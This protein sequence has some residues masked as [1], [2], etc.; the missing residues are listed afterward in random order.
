M[1]RVFAALL[2][3]CAAGTAAA[4]T[5]TISV[6]SSLAD[7]VREIGAAWSAGKPGVALRFNAAASGVLLQQVANGAPVDVLISADVETVER[8]IAAGVLDAASRRD[9][10][11]NTLVLVTPSPAPVPI[12]RLT[13]LA[14]PAVRRIAIGKPQ[15]VPAG[16]Y[17]QQALQTAG[18]W[19]AVSPKLVHADHV[20][21]A[22][23]YVSRGEV[24]AGFIYRSDAALAG[25]RLRIVATVDGH[26]AI[27]YP[28]LVVRGS[29]QVALA[30]AFIDHLESPAAAAVLNRHGFTPP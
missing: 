8:G 29:R 11:G 23:D 13:D 22:L 12:A 25:E 9:V 15:S 10:A 6:A 19:S 7:A 1:R 27:R 24:D 21:Q 2:L 4:Q 5:L 28:A 26:Q 20:R 16:R 14:A 18:L 30:A 17:A 3:A